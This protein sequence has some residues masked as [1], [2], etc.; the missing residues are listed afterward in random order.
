MTH[1]QIVI[2]RVCNVFESTL[3]KKLS[4]IINIIEIMLDWFRLIIDIL[5]KE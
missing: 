3:S 1:A 5:I 4:I 2:K